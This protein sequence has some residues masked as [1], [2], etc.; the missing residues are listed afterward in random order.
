ML[1][2]ARK[3]TAEG[4]PFNQGDIEDLGII[5]RYHTDPS[6]SARLGVTPPHFIGICGAPGSG[7]DLLT[8]EFARQLSLDPLHI[9]ADD[10]LDKEVD[11]DSDLNLQQI[12]FQELSQ[13][14]DAAFRSNKAMAVIHNFQKLLQD[15]EQRTLPGKIKDCIEKHRAKGRSLLV[16]AQTFDEETSVFFDR[17]VSISSPNRSLRQA[18]AV[19]AFKK[20]SV[21]IADESLALLAKDSKGFFLDELNTICLE[22]AERTLSDDGDTVTS[23]TIKK[24]MK[25]HTPGGENSLVDMLLGGGKGKDK[26]E[27]NAPPPANMYH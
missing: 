18:I 13:F 19:S 4:M 12:I 3:R 5:I 25:K 24:V 8:K 10:I 11:A 9:K 20:H 21:K 27:K 6:F 22:A 23:K 1:E 7:T 15:D 2:S 14:F 16:V 17:M 26:K